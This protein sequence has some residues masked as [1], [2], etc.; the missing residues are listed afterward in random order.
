VKRA[1]VGV[2]VSGSGS[3]LQALLDAA[4]AADYPAEIAVV[5]SNI[6]TALGLERARQAGVPTVTLESKTFSDRIA[7][8]GALVEALRAH[9]VQWVCLAGFMRLL[10]PTFLRAFPGAVLNIHPSLLPAFPGMHAVRQAVDHGAKVAGCTV[11]LVDEGT[12]TG[13]VVGQSAVPVLGEDDEAS[14][15]KRILAEEHKL[16]PRALRLMV[17]GRARVQGR[18][19][20]LEASPS[21]E[22]LALANPGKA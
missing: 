21:V 7:F 6:P 5:V 14:L 12:D 8:E 11:H 20:V 2:L 16:Y 17:E 3:N 1:R 9:G 4:S 18:R 22:G 19:V 13:P 15:G 10:G